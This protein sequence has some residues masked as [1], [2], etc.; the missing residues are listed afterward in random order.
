MQAQPGDRIVIRS[1]HVGEPDREGQ[2]LE[3]HGRDGN[4]PYVVRWLA[5]GHEGLVFP[6]PD[7]QIHH[8]LTT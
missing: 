2:I 1:A 5:D 8:S 6:G 7:T 4:P 3:V